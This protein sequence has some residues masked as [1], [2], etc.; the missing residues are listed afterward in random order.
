MIDYPRLVNE[1]EAI[2]YRG[3]LVLEINAPDMRASLADTMR[4]IET[5][6]GVNHKYPDGWDTLMV[7]GGSHL[8]GVQ[9]AP[10]V[11]EDP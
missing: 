3:L 1:L 5:Y 6:Y 9:W 8:N 7:D 2:N 10:P 11:P 4:M